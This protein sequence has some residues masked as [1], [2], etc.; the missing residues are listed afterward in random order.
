MP[1]S[2]TAVI[3]PIAVRRRIDQRLAPEQGQ[4]GPQFLLPEET[5]DV[6]E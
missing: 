6:R 2:T 3:S 5:I 4:I 1:A